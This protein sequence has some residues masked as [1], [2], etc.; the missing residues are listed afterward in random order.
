MRFSVYLKERGKNMNITIDVN[1][2]AS[3]EVTNAL[4][5]LAA[6]LHNA[7]PIF[8]EGLETTELK[9]EEKAQS[10]TESHKEQEPKPITL[11]NLRSKLIKLSKDGKKEDAIALINKFGGKKLTEVPKEN[12]KALLRE[13]E[14]IS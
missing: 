7:V 10:I 6:V 14:K 11:E 5:T 12:Y 9:V 13:V 2:K 4:L 8:D 3:E 1:F